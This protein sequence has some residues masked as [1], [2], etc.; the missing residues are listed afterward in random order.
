MAKNPT[1]ILVT[2]GTGTLG[3]LIVRRL[4]EGGDT[5]VRVLSRRAAPAQG[6]GATWFTGD[7][8]AGRG[9]RRA[10][11]GVDT[12]VHCAH[13][14]ASPLEEVSAAANLLTEAA[15][16][17]IRHFVYISIVGIDYV[18]LRYYR[19]K[20]AVEEL[21]EESGLPS[22]ILRTTQFHELIDWT[23]SQAERLPFVPVPQ[24]FWFQPVAAG[25][26]AQRLVEL[27]REEPAGRAVGMGGPEVRSIESLAESYELIRGR[28]RPV[29]K[30]PVPGK[31]ASAFR[32][33]ANLAAGRPV[34]RQT[35]EDFLESPAGE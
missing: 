28:R 30:I 15:Q 3:S 8:A 7:L 27:A 1:P 33:G 31:T 4:A 14:P 6:N 26:V 21:I 13:A 20:V 12:V 9:L 24:G 11:E 22:T 5:E 29:K 32:S 16:A 19:G 17:G 35:W 10:L 25:E 18:P 34:G 23:L 2:G